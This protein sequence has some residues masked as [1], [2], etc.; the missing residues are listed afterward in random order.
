M[1][2]K[3]L[4]LISSMKN[5]PRLPRLI[6]RLKKFNLKYKIFY[7]LEEGNIK[8]KNIIYKHYNRLLTK[9]RLG[10]EMGFNEIGTNYT[11]IRMFK[12]AIKKKLENF[13]LMGDDTYHS[14]ML[15]EWI[16]NKIYFKG[17]KNIGF[18]CFPPGILYKKFTTELSNKV[19]I[20]K[21]KTHLFNSNCNQHTIGYIKKFLKITRGK[22]IGQGDYPFNLK[23]NNLE[24]LQTVPFLCYP[25][26]H[27]FSYLR[28]DRKTLENTYFKNLRR[29]IY[30]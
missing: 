21:S 8:N 9:K 23:K 15:K 18:Q 14:Y 24:L 16:D 2:K 22:S 27:G 11:Q 20:Y 5:S 1:N 26:D 10:R 28:K 17:N 19:K 25:D 3:I 29:L 7:G 4:I 30:I 13:I 12:Y 6:N